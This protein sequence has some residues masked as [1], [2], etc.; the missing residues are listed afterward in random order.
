VREYAYVKTFRRTNQAVQIAAKSAFP[1]ALAS[2]VT[3]I[4]LRDSALAG[5]PEDRVDRVLT[6]KFDDFGI[7]SACKLEA[8]AYPL[9]L[10]R[11]P[12]GP[13]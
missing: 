6:I 5:E 9:A 10:F 4:D 1:P 11:R 7:F 8:L 12:L 13:V 2:A 3:D